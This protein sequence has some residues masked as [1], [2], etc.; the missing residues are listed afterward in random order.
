MTDEHADLRSH[1]H[2]PALDEGISATGLLAGVQARQDRLGRRRQHLKTAAAAAVAALVV[3]GAAVF[4]T[5]Q[6]P[7]LVTPA[8]QPSV[9]SGPT[10]SPA[11]P[12]TLSPSAPTRTPL[13]VRTVPAPAATAQPSVQPNR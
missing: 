5:R 10:V 3:V 13:P 2:D 7:E 6:Q 11:P 8:Q 12:T 9:T 1:L 4:T